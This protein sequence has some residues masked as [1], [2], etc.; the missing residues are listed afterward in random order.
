MPGVIPDLKFRPQLLVVAATLLA[1]FVR[2]FQLSS[3][4]PEAWFDEVWFALR[5]RELIQHPAFTVFYRTPW[6]GGNALMVYL[7]AAA[8]LLGFTGISSSRIASAALG[9]IAVP[10]AYA[11]FDEVLRGAFEPRT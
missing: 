1:A 4:A 6:G 8:Q 7:T 9:L 3:L 10:L 11:C 2:F 5:A